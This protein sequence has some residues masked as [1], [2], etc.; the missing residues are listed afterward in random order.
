M[1]VLLTCSLSH[2]SHNSIAITICTQLNVF[3]HEVIQQPD[4]LLEL[5]LFLISWST[6]VVCIPTCTKYEKSEQLSQESY[7]DPPYFTLV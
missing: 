6:L 4:P 2:D 1:N 7:I 5:F 3:I